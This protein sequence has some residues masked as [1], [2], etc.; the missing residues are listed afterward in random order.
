MENVSVHVMYSAWHL[1]KTEPNAPEANGTNSKASHVRHLTSSILHQCILVEIILSLFL[2]AT[3]FL[4]I[5]NQKKL[6]EKHSC[7]YF[8]N[9]QSVHMTSSISYIVYYFHKNNIEI[10]VNNALLMQM[11]VSLGMTTV[12]RL[13][14]INYPY[15]YERINSR[16]VI[17]AIFC[18][19]IPAMIFMVSTVMFTPSQESMSVISTCL[20]GLAFIVLILSN[21]N[22]NIVAR[23]HYNAI[24][25]FC[26]P[27]LMNGM[28][29]EK[30]MLK[31]TYVC[32]FIVLSFLLLWFPCFVH[33][34]ALLVRG[35]KKIEIKF[36]LWVELIAIFNSLVDP[37]LFVIL[38][39]DVKKE[40][41]RLL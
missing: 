11:F 15:R 9:L 16:T 34:I 25:K 8:L 28:K 37:V 14:E 40:L 31:S 21:I 19:W 17:G 2:N 33:N 35:Y 24:K 3:L 30:N 22:I 32:L 7:K 26:M 41:K 18:S 13:V 1:D 39:K 29:K 23:R 38:R 10:Y 6:W 5:V 27:A 36:T 4:I 12:D 20:I